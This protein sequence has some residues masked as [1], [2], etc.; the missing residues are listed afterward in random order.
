MTKEEIIDIW[1]QYKGEFDFEKEDKLLEGQF[2]QIE[3]EFLYALVRHIKPKNITEFSPFKGFTSMIMMRAATRNNTVTKL[4]SY[5]I[6]NDS[7]DLNC[8]GILTR[9]LILGHVQDNLKSKDMETCDFLF[10]DSDHHYNFGEWYST[11]LLPHL[12]AGTI[13]CIH[14]WPGYDFP[15]RA[16]NLY[17]P[18]KKGSKYE[19]TAVRKY[20]I[21]TKLGASVINLTDYCY[22]LGLQK[23]DEEAIASI[24]VLEKI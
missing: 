14:D 11:E 19:P 2:Q 10:I 16:R 23:I 7:S 3:S 17:R 21:D 4:T 12:K 5:D 18:H 6:I 20:F 15:F 8:T 22:E 13:I 24:Q 1:N 9:Q